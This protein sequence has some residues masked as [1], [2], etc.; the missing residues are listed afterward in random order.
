MTIATPS[1]K[2]HERVT[3][4][5][6]RELHQSLS[7]LKTPR[8]WI[9]YYVKLACGTPVP[10]LM[11]AYA[12]MA[13]VSR[14]GIELAAWAAGALTMI[15]ICADAM[16]ALKEFRFFRIGGDFF[17][18]AYLVVGV[19]AAVADSDDSLATLGGL[20]WVALLY[21]ITFCWELFPGLNRVFAIASGSAVFAA[22]YGIWQHFSGVDLI[23][24]TE[25]ASAP[26]AGTVFFTSVGFFNTPEQL[27]T[28][29]GMMLPFPVAAYLLDSR[30]SDRL[31]RY[32]ALAIAMVLA[33]G[34]LWTYR[35]G[36]WL[37][38]AIGMIITVIMGAKH[39]FKLL[40]SSALFVAAV[41]LI[42]Y[43]TPDRLISAVEG[44]ETKRSENQR[45]QINTQVKLWESSPWIGVGHSAIQAADYDPGTGNVYFQVL[46]QVGLLGAAFY[47][48][49]IL[50]F[51]L[52]TY[53]IFQE[54]PPSHYW[55][56]VL[57]AGSLASQ[58]TFHV[59]GLYWATLNEGMAINLFVL[60][61][62][63]TSYLSH[64]YHRGIVTD[65]YSL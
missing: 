12:F 55:H 41:L 8:E 60:V 1:A 35:P 57:V 40:G 48:L 49:F 30:R 5:W 64:H 7:K 52:A 13:F 50:G 17:L 46:A 4:R 32:F 23:R 19:V 26:V 47:L 28:F 18:L 11:C 38:G 27:G 58:I 59:A 39:A 25:L 42:S 53:R 15:Y 43:G 3:G 16:S 14:A 56:Q 34:I 20:R 10:W 22:L 54:I 44:A 31:P 33:L 6:D 9:L 65:D 62:S 51:L 2:S 61:A 45:A 63:A 24:S 21:A 29:L 37:A 36:M